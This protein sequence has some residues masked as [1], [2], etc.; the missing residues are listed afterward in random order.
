MP[1]FHARSKVSFPLLSPLIP[2]VDMIFFIFW[3]VTIASFICVLLS[4]C[5]K[6][7]VFGTKLSFFCSYINLET[8]FYFFSIN[9]F[10]LA[11]AM[12]PFWIAIISFSFSTEDSLIHSD[13][14]FKIYVFLV[15]VNTDDDIGEPFNWFKIVLIDESFW[16]DL[17][18]EILLSSDRNSLFYFPCLEKLPF[19]MLGIVSFLCMERASAIWDEL[20]LYWRVD[21]CFLPSVFLFFGEF[22]GKYSE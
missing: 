13:I 2:A 15:G 12:L 6:I 17:S 1:S 8:L 5:F 7:K 19:F 22:G 9:F 16:P 18:D 10:R 14:S 3:N 20:N 4:S 21:L 11:W